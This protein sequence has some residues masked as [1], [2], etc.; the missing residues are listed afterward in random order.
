REEDEHAAHPGDDAVGQQVREQSRRHL[1]ARE[2]AERA[3]GA[4]IKS[5]GSVAQEKIAWKTT[6]MT[7]TRTTGPKILCVTRRSMRSVALGR[8]EV[9]APLTARAVAPSIHR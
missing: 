8:P 1:R 3:E 9:C 4:V 7:T 2:L 6:A 5:I